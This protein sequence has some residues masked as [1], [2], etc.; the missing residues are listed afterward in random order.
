[1]DFRARHILVKSEEEA[2]SI[3][4]S[5][6]KGEKFENLAQKHSLCPSK[7]NGGDLG[8]FASGQMVPEFEK[9]VQT[10]D[11]GGISEPVET[12]FGYHVI[13]RLTTA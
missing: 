4:D 5:V 7:Q 12:Q 9:A 6:K 13:E 1:M 2:L 10:L 3:I 8:S 11:V